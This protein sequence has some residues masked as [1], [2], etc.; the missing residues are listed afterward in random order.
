LNGDHDRDAYPW[1]RANEVHRVASVPKNLKT[2]F[3][4]L[5]IRDPHN[6]GTGTLRTAAFISP[7]TVVVRS[8][9]SAARIAAQDTNVFRCRGAFA[10]SVSNHRFDSV[11]ET[12]KQ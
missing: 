11:G 12:V 2:S 4:M 8:V 3:E 1:P 9:W 5:L 10:V 7:T 6:A